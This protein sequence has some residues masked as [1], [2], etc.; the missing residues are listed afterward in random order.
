MNKIKI[1]IDK[2]LNSEDI[3]S[4]YFAPHS[5]MALRSIQGPIELLG[6]TMTPNGCLR[7][8]T[9]FLGE[10]TIQ[11]LKFNRKISK[12][13]KL[14]QQ[15]LSVDAFYSESGV[16][17]TLSKKE[18]LKP[19]IEDYPQLLSNFLDA[20]SGLLIGVH[21][22][23]SEITR[24]ERE[25]FAKKLNERACAGIYFR[26]SREL[27]F[28]HR[29]SFVLNAE[30]QDRSLY[31]KMGEEVDLVRYGAIQTIEDIQNI[32]AYLSAGSFV[33]AHIHGT[34]V[35]EALVGLLS[36]LTSWE[37]R[38]LMS[39]SLIGLY[40]FLNWTYGGCQNYAFE[41][42]PFGPESRQNFY[43]QEPKEF[44]KFFEKD[45]RNNGLSFSQSLHTKVLK[46]S[47]DLRKAFELAPDP[48]DLDYIL[49]KSGY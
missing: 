36:L 21:K 13:I 31:E 23:T 4:V 14:E 38:F 35:S 24:I 22:K 12:E 43:S 37:S 18:V 47:I 6:E 27:P 8:L 17:F 48:S 1:F 25:L 46:R 49:K 5:P 41:A 30:Q 42:Y 16:T 7:F 19:N 2:F 34:K 44:F 9:D 11:E 39:Q 15:T 28:F 26:D 40:S 3:R 29:G 33:M 20:P 10:A 45:F 32:N